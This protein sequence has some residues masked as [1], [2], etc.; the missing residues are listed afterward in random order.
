MPDI[1][2]A[3]RQAY[4]EDWEAQGGVPDSTASFSILMELAITI[5]SDVDRDIILVVD[6]IDESGE[7]AQALVESLCNLASTCSR[8][9][10]LLT[11]TE[12]VAELIDSACTGFGLQPT[13]VRIHPND[14]KRDIDAYIETRLSKENVLSKLRPQ[15]QADIRTALQHEHDGSFRWAQC[16]LDDLASLTTPKA[17][18]QALQGITPSLSNIYMSILLAIPEEVAE[19]A[20]SML[21]YLFA[22]LR[23]LTLTELAEAAVFTSHTEFDEDDRMID[24][25]AVLRHLRS[26]VRYEP[27]TQKVE[28]AHSSVRVFLTTR[29]KSGEFYIDSSSANQKMCRLC[30]G[31][32]L[33]PSFKSVCT[34]D[35]ELQVRKQNWPLLAYS[36]YW[37]AHHVRAA[38]GNI[39]RQ[40]ERLASAFF[41]SANQENGGHFAA[42]YQCA[43]PR[44]GS[45]TWTTKPLYICAREG[46]VDILKIVLPN[47]S[48]AQLEEKGGSRGSTALHVAAAFGETEAVELLIAAGADVHERNRDGET[49]LQWAWFW[50]HD[51][52]VEVLRQAGADTSLLADMDRKAIFVRLSKSECSRIS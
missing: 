38:G 28:L 5:C 14:V 40:V 32:L 21:T 3:A 35:S 25:E 22:A 46:L 15:L 33:L 39:S 19:V 13:S 45:R 44:R 6:A 41:D 20:G 49:G 30:L 37:W 10:L 34:T 31:Y 48:K 9:R 16:T 23:Q 27:I 43:Y 4:A 26:L 52:T 47:I 29:D 18:K 12:S 24:P 1:R 7:H 42:W 8:L 36:T 11:S 2:H 51:D 50:G 17:I